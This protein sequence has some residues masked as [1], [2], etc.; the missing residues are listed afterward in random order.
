MCLEHFNAIWY[1]E[2]DILSFTAG[3][4]ALLDSV[5]CKF[6]CKFGMYSVCVLLALTGA[7]MHTLHALY[8]CIDDMEQAEPQVPALSSGQ[9][10]MLRLF[11]TPWLG[12]HDMSHGGWGPRSWDRR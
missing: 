9:N 11:S 10:S 3:D 4:P 8:Y 12:E 7:P 6:S 1:L 2:Y 5:Y